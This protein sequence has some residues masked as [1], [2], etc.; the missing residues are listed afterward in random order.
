MRIRLPPDPRM[1]GVSGLGFDLGIGVLLVLDK[2]EAARPP[3]MEVPRNVHLWVFLVSILVSLVSIWVFLVSISLQS[4]Y[5]T[6]AKP[7]ARREWK[8][9][10]MYIRAEGRY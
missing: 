8:S 4:T 1:L 9:H 5:T 10:G 3:R 6:N 7:R 2:R